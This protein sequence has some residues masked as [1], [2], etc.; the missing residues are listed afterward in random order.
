MSPDENRQ[1]ALW[2]RLRLTLPVELDGSIRLS[3]R[4]W[5]MQKIA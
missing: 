4:A 1:A 5:A 3:A 2:E